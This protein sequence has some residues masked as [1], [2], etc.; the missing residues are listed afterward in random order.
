VTGAVPLPCLLAA[1][2]VH[3]GPWGKPR[4]ACL[5]PSCAQASGPEVVAAVICTG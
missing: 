1:G 2:T 4:D 3:G 5:Q